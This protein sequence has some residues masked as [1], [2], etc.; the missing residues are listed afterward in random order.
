MGA[1]LLY[2]SMASYCANRRAANDE[3]ADVSAGVKVLSIDL[4]EMVELFLMQ[5]KEAG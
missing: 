5:E 3:G 4:P 2:P 1:R